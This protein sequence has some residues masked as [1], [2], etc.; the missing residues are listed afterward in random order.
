MKLAIVGSRTCPQIDIEKYLDETSDTIISGGAIG[1]DTLAHEYAIKNGIKLIE[2]KPDYKLHGKIA[3]L[4]R[5]RLIV[6][7][8][9][10][11]LAFWD[12]KSKGTKFVIDYAMKMNKPVKTVY[13]K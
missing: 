7:E 10:S 11:V 1:A 9:D 4:V 2:F 3:P 6:D 12:G 8:C 13:I 5:N